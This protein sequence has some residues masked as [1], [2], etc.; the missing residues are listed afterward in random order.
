[1]TLDLIIK[2]AR[3]PNAARD[4]APTFEIYV[5]RSFAESDEPAAQCG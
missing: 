3:I 2:N 5:H 4:D 1:M